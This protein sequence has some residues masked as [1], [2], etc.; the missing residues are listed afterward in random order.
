MVQVLCNITNMDL[1]EGG[2][3]RTTT[4]A[5]SYS[6]EFEDARKLAEERRVGLWGRADK[7]ILECPLAEFRDELRPHHAH[8]MILIFCRLKSIRFS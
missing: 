6:R 7:R 4:F 2:Y 3:A 1:I 8:Q 5:H